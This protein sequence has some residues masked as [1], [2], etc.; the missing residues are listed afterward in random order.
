VRVINEVDLMVQMY[1]RAK[2]FNTQSMPEQ[3][4]CLLAD[5]HRATVLPCL[6]REKKSGVQ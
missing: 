5:R 4:G 1:C 3:K 2:L 6:C